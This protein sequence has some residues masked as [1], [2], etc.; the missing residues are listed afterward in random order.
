VGAR[1]LFIR[2]TEE[3]IEAQDHDKGRVGCCCSGNSRG[4]VDME[5][6]VRSVERVQKV[7]KGGYDKSSL[8]GENR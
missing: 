6:Y 1:V 8:Q 4:E 2:Q 5:M 3:R 7:G